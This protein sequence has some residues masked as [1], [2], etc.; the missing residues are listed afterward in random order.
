MVVSP[1]FD[2]ALS[3]LMGLLIGSFQCGD[4][5]VAQNDGASVAAGMC[6]SVW[7]RNAAARRAYNLWSPAPPVHIVAIDPL[8]RKH[9]GDELR[10]LA[11]QVLVMRYGNFLALPSNRTVDWRLVRRLCCTLGAD[12][13]ALVWCAFGAVLLTLGVI[14]W[15]TTLLPMT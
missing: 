7:E 4:T 9:T 3:A 10:F 2:V 14:D 15:D 12:A 1:G 11:R 5:S 13:Y 6:I 8:V